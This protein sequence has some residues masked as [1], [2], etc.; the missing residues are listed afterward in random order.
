M[1]FSTALCYNEIVREL[2][3]NSEVFTRAVAEI[4]TGEELDK[5]LSS[6]KKLRIKFGVDVTAPM[7]H[8][9]NAVNIWKMRELQE[10]GHRVLF[11]I[12]DFT[13]KIGDPTGKIDV[14]KKA[15]AKN[16]NIWAKN[17]I[18]EVSKILLTDKNVFEVRR[19]SEWFDKMSTGDLI[20]LFNLFTHSRV[21][22]R[23]MFQRRIKDGRE[24]RLP[25]LIYPILQG[26]DSVMLKSDLTI[27]GSD[28][29]FN[30]NMGRFLQVKFGQSPQVIVTTTITPGLDGGPKMSKSL[31]NYIGLED[32]P[33]DKFGKAM[34]LLDE[35]IIP[36]LESYTDVS[37]EEIRQM[38]SG[39]KS[40]RNPMEAK[41]F[42]AEELVG[43]YH[44]KEA[45]QNERRKFLK[46]FSQREL[47]D[48]APGKKFRY[49][50]W[51]MAVLLFSAGLVKSKTEARRLIMQN[52]IEVDG[53]KIANTKEKVVIKSG[54]IIRV[55]K[56]RFLKIT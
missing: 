20:N 14:R 2:T 1:E 40:G 24:I 39:L 19:N 26:Y 3:H 56:R 22:E 4:I 42:F 43:R 15:V 34:R 21:I 23:D 18:K 51:N 48:K 25:E 6:G 17:F 27:I 8:I 31:G 49:G 12:G 50:P 5:K 29:L 32:S 7:L 55:G 54:T 53:R 46:I 13:T 11:L 45:A 35:L 9:G 36:Y 28:Q 10:Q 44:G 52:A 37:L 47:P 16:I 38:G 41:L 30:E 33:T